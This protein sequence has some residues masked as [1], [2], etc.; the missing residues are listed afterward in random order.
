MGARESRQQRAGSRLRAITPQGAGGWALAVPTR[1]QPAA[2]RPAWA[3]CGM[4]SDRS[5][6]VAEAQASS[7]DASAF[8]WESTF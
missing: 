1:T 6:W 5:L 4:L 2:R 3:G 8:S 7:A